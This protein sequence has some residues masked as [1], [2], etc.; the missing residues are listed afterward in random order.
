[1]SASTKGLY[2]CWLLATHDRVWCTVLCFALA[3]V[4]ACACHGHQLE[5]RL[6]IPQSKEL[7]TIFWSILIQSYWVLCRFG[8]RLA[9]YSNL[10][11][12]RPGRLLD[13]AVLHY[14]YVTDKPKTNKGQSPL[15]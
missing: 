13:E 6:T 3:S 1:M 5:N 2:I 9:G 12:S 10:D 8:G 7:I 15:S 14:T 4:V 11:A